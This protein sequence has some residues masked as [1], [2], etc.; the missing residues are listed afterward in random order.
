MNTVPIQKYCVG[1]SCCN[2]CGISNPSHHVRKLQTRECQRQTTGPGTLCPFMPYTDRKCQSLC[3]FL[4]GALWK[5]ICW[6]ITS[7][8]FSVHSLVLSVS[9]RLFSHLSLSSSGMCISAV[10]DE[11]VVN[12]ALLCACV[13][14]FIFHVR[15]CS[16][17]NE[18]GDKVCQLGGGRGRHWDWIK[19]FHWELTSQN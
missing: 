15:T 8:F 9:L 5:D 13:C 19:R 10:S 1:K 11:R 14:V 3:R 17:P 6:H 12:R 16:L 18:T 2:R 4:H 7:C